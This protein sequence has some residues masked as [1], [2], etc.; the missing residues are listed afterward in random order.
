MLAERTFANILHQIQASNLNFHLQISPFSALIS[1]KKT[2]VKDKSGALI[3]PP[4]SPVKND[5]LAAL[6]AQNLILERDITTLN[7]KYQHAVDDCEA[8]H[9]KVKYLEANIQVKKE[10]IE[11]APF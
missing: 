8:A 6:T 1:L 9:N 3:L 10:P 11:T 2:L 4:A 7:N 5:E